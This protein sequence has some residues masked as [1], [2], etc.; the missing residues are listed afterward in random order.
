MV[1]HHIHSGHVTCIPIR[2]ICI[3]HGD[4]LISVTT[5][6]MHAGCNQVNQN[7]ALSYDDLHS[8]HTRT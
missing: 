4:S 7:L 8:R 1:V 5:M 6:Q 2:I 3:I